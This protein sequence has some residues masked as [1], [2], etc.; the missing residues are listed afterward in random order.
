[1]GVRE[2][3]L[4]SSVLSPKRWRDSGMFSDVREMLPFLELGEGDKRW[5]VINSEKKTI[6]I[7]SVCRIQSFLSSTNVDFYHRLSETHSIPSILL[8]HLEELLLLT[9]FLVHFSGG[10]EKFLRIWQFIKRLN[11]DKRERRKMTS[12]DSGRELKIEREKR[13]GKQEKK[14]HE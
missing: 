7:C 1:M 6:Q 12:L 9:A 11:E 8:T 14:F 5:I 3:E 4:F 2:E 10:H 13:D